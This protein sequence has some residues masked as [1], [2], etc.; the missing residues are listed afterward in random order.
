MQPQ[1]Q[2]TAATLSKEAAVM[3]KIFKIY[4]KAAP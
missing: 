3:L 4:S 2:Q 1:Q